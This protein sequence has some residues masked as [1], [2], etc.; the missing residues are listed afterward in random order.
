MAN[1]CG[2]SMCRCINYVK[3]GAAQLF[4]LDDCNGKHTS[5]CYIR[6]A[7]DRCVCG[8]YYTDHLPDIGETKL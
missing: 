1:P 2:R 3:N 5:S 4:C 8:H 6:Y 7:V